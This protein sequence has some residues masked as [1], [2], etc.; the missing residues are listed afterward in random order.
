MS[1]MVLL[2]VGFTHWITR[3]M[4]FNS[5]LHSSCIEVGR[6]F[7]PTLCK[8]SRS[9]TGSCWASS[10]LHLHEFNPSNLFLKA[11]RPWCEIGEDADAV[12]APMNWFFCDHDPVSVR[13]SLLHR[14]M[15]PVLFAMLSATAQ[16]SE[17]QFVRTNGVGQCRQALE[18]V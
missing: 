1:N 11:K 17:C 14:S 18:T 7:W 16:W 4:F 12:V 5:V 13:L 8:F 2:F 3:T 10:I 6:S 9:R 15:N